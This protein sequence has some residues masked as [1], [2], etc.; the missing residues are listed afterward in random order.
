VQLGIFA[1]SALVSLAASALLVV[2]LERLGERLG[3]SDAMLGLLAAL[4]ADGPNITAAITA[5][6]GGHTTVGVGVALGSNVFI[7]AALLGL[8]ALI[9]GRIGFHRRAVLLE[10]GL[11]LW[12][13]LLAI[14][15]VAGPAAPA[16]GLFLVLLAFVPYVAYAA[17][18]PAVRARL[19][20][21]GR[22]SDWLARA[23]AEEEAE[24]AVAIR[25]RRGDRR[26]AGIALVAVIVV[27]AASAVMERAATTLGA[28][29]G[30]PDIVV[31]GLILAAVT[32]LPNAV[33]AIYLA[34]RGRG[35]ATLSTAFNSNAFN[36]IVGLLVPGALLG[37]ARP[38][39]DA[40]FVAL[41]YLV[42]TGA[43]IA[44]ALRGRGLDRRAGSMIIV[45][46]LVFAVV[47]ASR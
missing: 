6:A 23:L 30:L 27:V 36:V 8:S 33:A 1:F 17:E 37:L 7:L 22:W 32:S 14:A 38:S 12:I 28:E 9:V 42:L 20:L 45:G 3:L 13:A 29:A 11:G 21:P 44:L 4:A 16:L 39:G 46:Y 26:D 15:V 25:P 19:R 40:L 31:G 10:G 18:H 41:C 43:S 35:A 5:I 47:L 34:S 24:L 2:R